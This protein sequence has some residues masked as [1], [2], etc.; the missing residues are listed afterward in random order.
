MQLDARNGAN[1]ADLPSSW[2]VLS[3]AIID[4]SA[5]AI[6][7]TDASGVVTSWNRA[8]ERLYG[9]TAA[10]IVGRPIAALIPSDRSAEAAS[11]RERV[12]QGQRLEPYETIRVRKDGGVVEVSL[13]ESSMQ[14]A[15]GAFAGIASIARD[16]TQRKKAEDKF[17]NLLEA[18][19]DAMV[20]A[21]QDGRIVL[22]NA[23]LERVFGHS[24]DEL[25]GRS[26]EV[27]IPERFRGAHPG[28]RAGYFATPRARAMGSGLE[29][30]G[31]RKDGTE[32]PVEIS[33]S[34]LET[35]D[36]VLVTSAI[37]D[38]TERKK[39]E[40]QARATSQY[41][42]SLIEASLDPLVTISP[43]GKITD[44][45][46]ATIKVTGVRR[47]AL[48]GTDFSIYFTDHDKAREGYREA[49]SKG[50]VTDYPLTIRNEDGRLTDVLYNATVYKDLQG[51]VLGVFAA[52]RDVT[53][54]KQ[55]SQYARSLIEASLDPLVTISPEGKITDVNEGSIKVTG[56]PREKLIGTDFSD[57]FTEPDK[58]REGYQQVFA[59]GFV[60]DYPLTIRHKDGWLTDVLYNA[61]VYK[62]AGGNVLGVFAAARD[63]TA[64]KQASQYARSLI[65]ASLDP[66]VTISPE[67]KI[68]DVN[69]GSIKVT[70]VARERLIG[71]DFSDYF[72]EPDKAREGYQQ[73]FAQGFVT[74][75]PL[76]IRHKDGR[77]TDVLYNASVYKDAN[78]NVLGVFAAA[79]D[80]TQQKQA[81][82]Y[83]RSLIEASLDPLVTISSEGKITD[84]NEAT[85]KVTG[86]S[87]ERLVGTDFSDYFTEPE[88]AREGYQQVFAKG[89][90]TDYPLTIRSKDG[91]HTDV[92][93]NASVYRDGRGNVIGVFAAARNV[94]DSKRV[95]REFTET[96][97]LLDN[98][99]QSSIKYSIIG[100]DLDQRILS[101]NEGAQRNYGYSAE[102]ILGRSS[103]ILHAPEDA[104]SGAV[105]DLLDAAYRDGLAEGEFER[106]RRDGSRFAAS[107]VVTR[108]NDGAG[109]PIGYLL[110]SS[111]ISEKK[112]A[113]ERLRSASQY[114]RSLIEASVDPLVTISPAGK[115]T[116][117]NEATIKV[118]GVSR[119]E[120][121][122]TDFSNYFTEPERARAGYQQVFAKGS[123]TDYPLTIRHRNQ[124]LTEVL[125]NA[126][127]YRDAGGTVLGVFA[128]ARDVTAQ[129]RAEMEIAEQR[130]KE[131]ER[132]VELERFQKLTVGRELKMIELKKEIGELKRRLPNGG[133]ER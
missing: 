39:A 114:S 60:T 58:A 91:A 102:E 76:T 113:E 128:A 63:V 22:V 106:V 45:N 23:Q 109:N 11:I 35:E 6:V 116:D 7:S 25:V 132:L 79:R 52:A 86:L 117:V 9:Y 67:G 43:D 115:I 105:K 48:I 42:R 57:Y 20:I 40:D 80:V 74:D 69:E 2:L 68:T 129:K 50:S 130:G 112:Q 81:S 122:G 64:Q 17:R 44:V 37:R 30:F 99:L 110:M 51:R 65:E 54:Q 62:D 84:V 8:A 133:F 95:M 4:S 56:V 31:L 36:G 131:L 70:G 34:P 16:L 13:M 14:D 19:P 29:L 120:L 118:T 89:F 55:A 53:E 21:G 78:G 71:T 121:I 125:Y 93:Y 10:E 41:A 66:L 27:L 87:R 126:S 104:S 12:A 127:V 100:K 108:R 28:H 32:F 59:Q 107:V 1:R 85:I 46:E 94:T 88:K 3:S 47:D 111:D 124:I 33:L 72:T 15:D 101:W 77:L 123:V 98:I 73:V 18:A 49:F 24:R 119:E 83:A 75:Y 103:E 38:I 82:Q 92:L 61:S 90:V 26:V 97:N 5:D 96:K